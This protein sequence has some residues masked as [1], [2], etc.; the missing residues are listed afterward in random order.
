MHFLSIRC[1]N[2]SGIV[3]VNG[4]ER[5]M[6]VFRK[7]SRYILQQ[8]IY[9]KFLTVREAMSYAADLKL[10]DDLTRAEKSEVIEEIVHLLRLDKAIDTMGDRLS[11]GERKRL[12]IALELVNN[13][14][15]MFLDEP[16]T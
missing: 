7:M 15:I 1:S 5:D 16:T 6:S 4:Q 10:G 13:P 8:D 2:T 12:S 11:G 9:P 14:P 3:S